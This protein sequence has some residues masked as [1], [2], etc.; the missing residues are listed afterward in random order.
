MAADRENSS[1]SGDSRDDGSLRQRLNEFQAIF[2]AM[3]DGLLI[4]DHQTRQFIRANPTVCLMLGYSEDE[5]LRMS[6][7]DIHP[8]DSLPHVHECFKA[9]TEGRLPVAEGLPFQRKD[10]SVF[11][12]DVAARPNPISYHGRPC[13]I[14]FIRDVSERKRAEEELAKARETAEAASRAKGEFLANM[15]HEIRTP[16]TSILG[17]ADLL[18]RPRLSREE[19]HDYLETIRRNGKLLLALI[20][21][22][23]DLSKIEAGKMTLE[24]TGCS[25]WRIAQD[26]VSMM[27]VR[28]EEKGL[29]LD[30]RGEFP[31]PKAIR[32]DPVRLR[33]ILVN[34]VG[35]AIKFTESGRVQVMLR[36]AASPEAAPPMEFVVSDTG[37]GMTPEQVGELFEPF[38]QADTST[39]RRFGGTGL[40][41]A[42]S[43]RLA[44]ML[45]GDIRVE[46]RPGK[47][48]TFAVSIDPGPL[49]RT[50]M[51]EA[52]PTSETR[53]V[54]PVG[55]SLG[56]TLRGR[57]LLAEDT[58]DSQRLIVLTLR[59]AGL[60]VDAVDNGRAAC[61]MAGKSVEEENPYDLILMDV[62]M[63]DLDGLE[64]TRRLRGDGWQ[65]P[66]VALTAHAMPGDS[67]KCLD[68]GCDEYIAKPADQLELLTVVARH[69]GQ[70]LESASRASAEPTAKRQT[71]MLGS[72]LLSKSQLAELLGAF[73][74]ELPDRVDMIRKAF[75][76]RDRDLLEHLTHQLKGS[77][78]IYGFPEIADA[79][80]EVNE[81]A[82]AGN[83]W[84]QSQAA[85][86]ELATL[87]DRAAADFAG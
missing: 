73:F 34:L 29:D 37:I 71:G 31:L 20:N 52:P 59:N 54:E 87:C 86:S 39:T 75:D 33:Q 83:N 36:L 42:I 68:A 48:S 13:M 66:V 14:A 32:S 16:M 57:V 79:A 11:H 19:Q 28:A 3:P 24:R 53:P 4:V 76:R 85:V 67:R 2:D 30:V 81:Q 50:E 51:L 6:V 45:G 82:G 5:L 64:A 8:K 43:R 44:R 35:N 62:E 17:Y 40:G 77:A 1:E 63:Q 78:A 9:Q 47:G 10:G 69:L 41:L 23:L 55:S 21:D 74:G 72:D 25:P 15:S 60:E 70:P 49:E 18:A 12:A 38:A 58:P 80:R 61:Q 27:R 84:Q 56:G 65:G 22:V 7:D 46:S 26:A